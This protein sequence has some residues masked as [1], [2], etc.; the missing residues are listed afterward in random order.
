M[1]NMHTHAHTCTQK[2]SRIRSVNL[3]DAAVAAPAPAE[4][5]MKCHAKLLPFNF[6]FLLI[7]LR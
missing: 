4:T 2:N 7:Y 6:Y 5:T 3:C 1:Y